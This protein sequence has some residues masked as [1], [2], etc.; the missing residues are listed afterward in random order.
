MGIS[1]LFLSRDQY[2]AR[3]VRQ[4]NQRCAFPEE[5]VSPLSAFL[6]QWH[7]ECDLLVS[8]GEAWERASV[9]TQILRQAPRG[10]TKV[11]L[12]SGNPYLQVQSLR[13][14]GLNACAWSW[15]ADASVTSYGQ[16]LSLLT[17]TQPDLAVFWVFALDACQAMGLPPSLESLRSVD[18]LTTRWMGAVLQRNDQETAVD[19]MRRY[20]PA[21]AA[22]AASAAV[23]LERLGR[24]GQDGPARPLSHAFQD[25]GVILVAAVPGRRS[26]LAAHYLALLTDAMER[27]QT[28]LLLT[29]DLYLEH[30]P[31]LAAA[32]NVRLVLA[33]Q[34]LCA[35]AKPESLTD[36]RC[37]VVLF[38][39]SAAQSCAA[40]S[41]HFLGEY[42]RLVPE[43]SL[44]RTRSTAL[45]SP[46]QHTAS[47][48]I[49][50]HKELRL[51]PNKLLTLSPGWGYASL[52]GGRE[53]KLYLTDPL[54][55][56]DLIRR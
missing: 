41:R 46:A 2:L 30:H 51:D 14:A 17:Q 20:D 4:R 54:P 1:S 5:V 42:D 32:A 50:E 52:P 16:L 39:H 22:R 55:G 44:S 33:A 26:A 36:R 24:S 28:F 31:L 25:P 19:L 21:M 37:G 49:R 11:V 35:L 48:T 40:L 34:D 6:D 45:F 15:D 7:L 10:L 27:R 12:S 18:W 53:G 38:Q 8:G 13:A 29:D 43:R 9:L 23:V 3:Q 47:L 56:H